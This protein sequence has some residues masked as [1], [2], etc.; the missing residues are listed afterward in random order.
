MGVLSIRF[1][2]SLDVIDVNGPNE[3]GYRSLELRYRSGFEPA[4]M[5]RE[6]LSLSCPILQ[7][8]SGGTTGHT[9]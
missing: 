8:A 3:Q 1:T 2:V 5:C 7:G 9:E 6:L 4:T